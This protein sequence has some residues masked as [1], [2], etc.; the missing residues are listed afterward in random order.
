MKR[1]LDLIRHILLTTEDSNASELK[2][3]DYVTN[4]YSIKEISYHITLLIEADYIIALRADNLG[5]LYPEYIVQRLTYK[6][7]DFLDTIRNDNVFNKTKTVVKSTVGTTALT[8]VKEIAVNC[9]KD[10]LGI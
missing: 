5:S 7:H 1:N 6:G 10:L 8:L 2:V 4:Q 9:A 3:N